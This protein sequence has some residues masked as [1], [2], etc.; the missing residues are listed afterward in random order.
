M[1]QR[2]SDYRIAGAPDKE[3]QR[4][5]DAVIAVHTARTARNIDTIDCLHRLLLKTENP[6]DI[7]RCAKAIRLLHPKARVANIIS[8][9]HVTACKTIREAVHDWEN[10]WK[11]MRL[12]ERVMEE[13]ILL[14]ME[15]VNRA[16]EIAALI[17]QNVTYRDSIAAILEDFESTN[18]L[19]EGAL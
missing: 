12:V 19:L 8:S 2:Y 7:K 6:G 5:Q 14:G 13:M 15:N 1:R 18:V 11:P 16:D 4:K 17:R 9:K 3:V 10:N